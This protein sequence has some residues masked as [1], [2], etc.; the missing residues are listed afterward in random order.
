M[1][2]AED[3]LKDLNEVQREA[4][5]ADPAQPLLIVAGAGSGKTRILT[6][7]IAYLIANNVPSFHILGITFTN[8]AAEE[9]RKRV[10]QM[11]HHQVWISTF[12]ATC[13]QIL[14]MDGEKMGL[15]RSFAIYDDTDQIILV[16]E[17]MRD[18]GLSDKHIN[19]KGAREL[20]Q[21]AKDQLKTPKEIEEGAQDYFEET[22]AKIYALYQEKLAG[23]SGCD[24]GDLIMKT[25][26][27]FNAHP[28]VLES[29]QN[30]FQHILIDEYQDT[31]RA[32]YCFVN[33]LANKYKQ[34]T[35]VGDP[36][37][38]IYAWRGADIQNILRFEEDY[39]KCAI[40]KLEQNYRSTQT[41]LDAANQLIQKNAARKP[42]NLWTENDE[43]EKIS[44]Y[45]AT[46]ELD[47]AR[48]VVDKIREHKRQGKKF[49]DM[50]IF[51]RVHAQSRLIEDA[52]RKQKILYKIIGGIRFYDRREVKDLIAYLRVIAFPDDAV[53]LKRIMNVPTRGIGK[54]ALAEIENFQII[55]NISLFQTLERIQEIEA[56]GSKTG[57]QI[58]KFCGLINEMRSKAKGLLISDILKKVLDETGYLTELEEERTIES[59]QRLENIQEFFSAVREFEETWEPGLDQLPKPGKEVSHEGML[60]AFL[61]SIALRSPTDD[62]EAETEWLTMMTIHSAKGLEFPVVFMVGMEEEIFPHVNSFGE[63]IRELE[64]ERRLC[65]VGMTRAK[66]NLF[67]TFANS[68][69]LY[70]FREHNLPS[71]FL[72]EI[73]AELCDMPDRFSERVELDAVTEDDLDGDVDFDIDPDEDNTKRRILFG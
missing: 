57:L 60:D 64:E 13:V 10:G 29:W 56:I 15:K 38:S 21:R 31:N 33:E 1:M 72:S 30:R 12:H 61:E 69:R 18:L 66:E 70:G 11:V 41:I 34:I 46:D 16:K 54:K 27:L 52:L 9:M 4:V 35:V 37:Q 28:A 24:F 17:C 50:V 49:S 42:K 58:K 39:P 40:L 47:E 59:K 22:V 48:Y 45:E 3:L 55:Q 53:A 14:R 67:L 68:R 36:D 62:V 5:I 19:P 2:S 63:D 8:K 26:Q 73:P 6:R 7:R 23:L 20:I 44:L 65:Y 71:R 25:V 51:Y 43:G 32:Q